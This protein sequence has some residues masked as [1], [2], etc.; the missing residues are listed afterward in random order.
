[1]LSKNELSPHN[2]SEELV[3]ITSKYASEFT[4]DDLVLSTSILENIVQDTQQLS[5]VRKANLNYVAIKLAASQQVATNLSISSS[6]NKSVKMRLVAT[7]HLQTCYN[8]LL[9]KHLLWI[10]R[11]DSQLATSLLTSNNLQHIFRQQAVANH[12]NEF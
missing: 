6:C 8:L 10:T 3:D 1:M 5:K 12:A 4:E 11:F 9:T 2:A 7:F